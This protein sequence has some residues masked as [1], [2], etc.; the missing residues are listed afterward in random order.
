MPTTIRVWDLPTRAFHWVLVLCIAAL[1]VTANIGGGAMAWHFR[2]GYVVMALLLFRLTWG[3]VGGRWSR[4]SSF[5]YGPVALWRFLRGQHSAPVIG[6]SP[7]G[8]LSVF[9]MLLF[10]LAQVAS[11]LFSDDEI[12]VSGPFSSLASSSWVSLATHYHTHV[13]KLVVL[14]LI[15]MHIA[16]IC[17]Y[18]YRRG[19]NLLRPMILG[20]KELSQPAPS[21]RDDLLTRWLAALLFLACL[22]LISLALSL[23]A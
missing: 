19:Q 17:F 6:H 11:G 14:S 7:I 5:V 8:A 21:S 15:V 10:L 23:Q 12:S 4:F 20:D 22:A 9:A 3:F 16:A 1:L 18:W 13:G 2:F